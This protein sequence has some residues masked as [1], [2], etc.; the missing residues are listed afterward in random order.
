[1]FYNF[2]VD[3]LPSESVP[4]TLRLAGM[5]VRSENRFASMMVLWYVA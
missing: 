3:H 5:P 4:C 1:M 2:H